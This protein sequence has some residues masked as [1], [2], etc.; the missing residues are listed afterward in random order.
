MPNVTIWFNNKKY[1]F[2]SFQIFDFI[3]PYTQNRKLRN[4]GKFYFIWTSGSMCNSKSKIRKNDVKEKKLYDVAWVEKNAHFRGFRVFV[5]VLYLKFKTCKPQKVC[6]DL[7]FLSFPLHWAW[8]RLKIFIEFKINIPH[9][10]C[11]RVS[12]QRKL[13]PN[14]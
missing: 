12:C 4:L 7:K 14:I 10:S 2:Q 9:V 1:Q 6:V 13:I 8:E 11:P 3:L 5:F